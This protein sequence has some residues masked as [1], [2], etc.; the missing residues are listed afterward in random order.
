ML[1]L[2]I[3][4][5]LIVCLSLLACFSEYNIYSVLSLLFFFTLIS[6]LLFYFNL[7]FLG[8]MIL[9]IYAGAIAVF[10]V[11]FMFLTGLS[12]RIRVDLTFIQSICLAFLILSTNLSLFK[13]WTDAQPQVCY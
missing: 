6:I 8:L 2:F 5:N 13:G 1:F 12:S 11:F 7:E 9:I 10:F 3:L 4:F